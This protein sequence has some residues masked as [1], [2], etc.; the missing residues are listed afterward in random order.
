MKLKKNLPM[1]KSANI[2]LNKI[3]EI[4]PVVAYI[5][6]RPDTV[7]GGTKQ[8]LNKYAFPQA[9][10]I[11]K[12][13]DMDYESGNK[14]KVKILEKLYP[15]IL[16]IIDDNAKL[17][18]YVDKNYEGIIFLYDHDHVDSKSNAIAC[19]NWPDTHKAVKKYFKK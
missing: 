8:W 13:V 15:N 11:A 6:V 5:T 19:K 4:I 3:N 17:L 7:I 18:Q 9:P 1:I 2:Y 16:G 14:W 10:V 12:S